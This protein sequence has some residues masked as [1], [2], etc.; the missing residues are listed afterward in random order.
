MHERVTL[1]AAIGGGLVILAS[2][3]SYVFE[4]NAGKDKIKISQ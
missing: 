2:V 3:W 4:K 1:G